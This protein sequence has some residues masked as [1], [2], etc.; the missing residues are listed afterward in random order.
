MQIE[1]VSDDEFALWEQVLVHAEEQSAA[2]TLSRSKT[3]IPPVAEDLVPTHEAS[4]STVGNAVPILPDLEDFG[5]KLDR[6]VKHRPVGLVVTDIT[7]SEWCQQQLA[8]TLSARL[9]KV[10]S[11][12][13]KSVH[14]A[15]IDS[16]IS[17]SSPAG[18]HRDRSN[19]CW[20]CC[21]CSSRG[22]AGR[23]SIQFALAS[24]GMTACMQLCSFT[25]LHIS[26]CC[27]ALPIAARISMA[28]R[29]VALAEGSG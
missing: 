7:N 16:S 22:R 2:V 18:G 28:S 26:L 29:L 21:A 15:K 9:P 20:H 11:L 17:L 1:L 3:P 10:C 6:L 12:V 27:A 23:G 13:S 4:G 14:M 25:D 24:Y 5:L 8:F 19:G